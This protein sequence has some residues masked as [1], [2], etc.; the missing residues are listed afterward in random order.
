MLD[1]I[2]IPAFEDNYIWLLHNKRY[3]VV[4]DPGDAKPVIETLKKLKKTFESMGLEFIGTVDDGAGVRWK[5]K[6]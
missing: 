4:V 6:K 5:S 2:P 3:A 1:I